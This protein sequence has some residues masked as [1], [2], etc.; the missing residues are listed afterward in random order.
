MPSYN[1]LSVVVDPR[2]VALPTGNPLWMSLDAEVLY[3][4]CVCWYHAA[5]RVIIQP[6]YQRSIPLFSTDSHDLACQE[7]ASVWA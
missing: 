3:R 2:E 4:A 6:S 1:Q 7:P 5:T